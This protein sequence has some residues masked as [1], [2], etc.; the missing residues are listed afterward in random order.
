MMTNQQKD[1]IM[2]DPK[3]A[4]RDRPQMWLHVRGVSSNI[5]SHC[6]G[7]EWVITYNN[8]G[9]LG[10]S[11]LTTN[12][13]WVGYV[14]INKIALSLDNSS[15]LSITKVK[16]INWDALGWLSTP[17]FLVLDRKCT[18]FT[19]ILVGLAFFVNIVQLHI[20]GNF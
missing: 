9:S 12:W 6:L 2:I 5:I 14:K 16:E 3:K 19:K 8:V 18:V 20:Q 15:N 7:K 1:C 11:S 10:T 4:T 13:F 17:K